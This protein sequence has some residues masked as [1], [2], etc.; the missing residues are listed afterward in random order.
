MGIMDNVR[1][2]WSMF[3]KK[4]NEPSLVETD[5]KYQQTFEP[6]ALNP[7]NT[8]PQRTYKRSSIASMIFNRIAMDASMVTYQHVKIVNDGVDDS[9]AN[10]VVQ[11]STQSRGGR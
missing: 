10:Q 5:K 11:S 1:H 4:P 8:I 9:T 2:A 6:R 3:A 7:N